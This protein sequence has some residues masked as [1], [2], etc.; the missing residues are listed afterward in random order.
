M[1]RSVLL[2]GLGGFVGSVSRYWVQQYF[3]RYVPVGFPLGTF[4]VNVVG[5]L[6][7]GLFLGFFERHTHV[8][9]SWRL[10]LTTGFCGGFTTF[11]TFAYESVTLGRTGGL[12]LLAIYAAGS[13]LL[14]MLAAFLG[15][16]AARF[17]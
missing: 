15:F 1:N 16:W 8:S 17:I 12:L 3:L 11:S 7:I 5:C 2:I 9:L 6:L 10:F 4:L 14:G 13:L